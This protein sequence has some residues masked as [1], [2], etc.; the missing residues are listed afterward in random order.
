MAYH[1]LGG[2]LQAYADSLCAI[3]NPTVNSFKRIENFRILEPVLVLLGLP[4]QLAYSGNN[5]THLVRVPDIRRFELRLMDGATTP[6]LT[7]W[8]YCRWT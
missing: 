2:V 4:M 6:I 1:F 3:F 5:R 8:H 7:G